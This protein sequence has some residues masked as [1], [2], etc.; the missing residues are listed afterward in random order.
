MNLNV[1]KIFVGNGASLAIIAPG[2]PNQSTLSARACN[3]YP[4][5]ILSS[6]SLERAIRREGC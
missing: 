2:I 3:L 1:F 6:C 5:D 4:S